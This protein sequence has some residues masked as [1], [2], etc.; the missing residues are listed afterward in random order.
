MNGRCSPTE[1]VNILRRYSP[2]GRPISPMTI[3]KQLTD[4]INHDNE[5]FRACGA[6]AS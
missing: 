5:V 1:A 6:T 4:A 2:I 3:A